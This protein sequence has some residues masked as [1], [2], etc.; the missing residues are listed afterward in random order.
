MFNEQLHG[1]PHGFARSVRLLLTHRKTRKGENLIIS[2]FFRVFRVFRLSGHSPT[3]DGRWLFIRFY[4]VG[5]TDHRPATQ[6]LFF[7]ASGN[8]RPWVARVSDAFVPDTLPR[9]SSGERRILSHTP[10][11]H[12]RRRRGIRD[13]FGRERPDF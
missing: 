11:L 5:G 1:S 3:D 8:R 4:P 9:P 10:S 2:G 6:L 12:R 13:G 7:N